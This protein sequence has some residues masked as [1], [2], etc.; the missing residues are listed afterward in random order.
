MRKADVIHFFGSV[1]A[2]ATALGITS[3]AVSLWPETVP[4]GRQFQLEKMTEG[5]LKADTPQ[6]TGKRRT[7]QRA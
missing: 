1:G 6:P 3:Q 5:R 4:L 2:V 7:A